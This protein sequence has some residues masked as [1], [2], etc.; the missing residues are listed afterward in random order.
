MAGSGDSFDL[1]LDGNW[2]KSVTFD[3][4]GAQFHTASGDFS[5]EC[6][7]LCTVQRF[8]SIDATSIPEPPSLALVSLALLAL[9][10]GSK[11][12]RGQHSSPRC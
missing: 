10:A 7:G 4:I 8:S 9:G 3:P 6:T 2:G 11:F 12:S 1:V 5:Y